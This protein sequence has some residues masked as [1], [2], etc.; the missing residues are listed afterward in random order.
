MY[1]KYTLGIETPKN[2][3]VKVC[4]GTINSYS[5]GIN[6]HVDTL[7]YISSML[8]LTIGHFNSF[9]SI[10]ITEDILMFSMI[11]IRE[12]FNEEVWKSNRIFF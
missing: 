9:L 1:H 10:C 7:L 2:N 12:T 4:Y 8:L 5:Y 11:L 3:I 6:V